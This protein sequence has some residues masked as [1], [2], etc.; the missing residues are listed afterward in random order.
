MKGNQLR[1]LRGLGLAA[2]IF[3]FIIGCAA[4]THEE[5]A[6]TQAQRVTAPP[7]WSTGVNPDDFRG[8]V[9]FLAHDAL[10]GRGIG[11]PGIDIAA[12][13][14]AAQFA[15]LGV[16]PGGDGDSYFQTFEVAI[17]R[18]LVDDGYFVLSGVD[19][20]PMRGTDYI[21]FSFSSND[22]F[23]AEVVFAGYG[24]VNESERHDDYKDLDVEGKAVLVLRRMPAD[25]DDDRTNVRH[26]TFRSKVYE[27]EERG[28]AAVLIVNRDEGRDEELVPFSSS[29]DAYGLP[30]F[31]ITRELAGAMLAGRAETLD[32]LQAGADEGEFVSTPLSGLRLSAKAGVASRMAEVRNVVGLIR[33]EGSLADE[34]IVIGAHYDHI[35]RTAP[36]RMSGEIVSD[37]PEIHNGADDNASGTAGVIEAARMLYDRRPLRRSVLLVAFTGEETGLH[38]SRHFVNNPPVALDQIVAMLNMDMIGRLDDDTLQV[39]GTKAAVEFEEMIPR[40]VRNAGLQLRGDKSALGPSD[41]THFY[42]KKI[43][44]LHFFT[45]LHEDYHR[46]SDD[47]DKVNAE[48]GARVTDVV[49]AIAEEIINTDERPTYFRVQQRASLFG[50]APRVVMGIMPGYTSDDGPGMKVE[51]VLDD[52]PAAAGGIHD[53]DRIVRIDDAK[54]N[55]IHDYMDALRNRK[56]GDRVTVIVVRG[57]EEV[58]LELE[59]AER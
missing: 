17:E 25:W 11:T 49:V 40:I 55:N 4:K 29:P 23:E 39:F 8:H 32:Q 41:H 53:G 51:G 45:G 31:H 19:A 43:P 5:T 30:V 34:Y 46:P 26:A 52:G 2:A 58:E 28:A 24:I 37:Q 20:D 44:S 57:E 10:A 1:H 56:A 21:P 48:G 12:G 35:G 9:E 54:V 14:I 38:G 47:A 59:L 13:Y 50:R 18:E 33:G 42:R 36:R 15:I 3:A 7:V 16:E 22:E 27:A 6:Y